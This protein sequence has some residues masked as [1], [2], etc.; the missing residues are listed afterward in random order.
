MGAGKGSKQKKANSPLSKRRFLLPN[1]LKSETSA[2][3]ALGLE[4]KHWPFLGLKPAG[5]WT[6]TMPFPGFPAC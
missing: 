1:C 6:K 5:L 3:P 4:L 2:F